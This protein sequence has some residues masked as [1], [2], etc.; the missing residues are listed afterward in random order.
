[1]GRAPID[2]VAFG[3]R[4]HSAGH[5][6]VT[7]IAP[8]T[9]GEEL[10]A[11]H[12]PTSSSPTLRRAVLGRPRVGWGQRLGLESLA[13]PRAA[14]RMLRW[15]GRS[16]GSTCNRPASPL[17]YGLLVLGHRRALLIATPSGD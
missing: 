6:A 7:G 10:F 15:S 13:A 11:L 5:P 4:P 8:T 17:L 14:S 9:G 2:G 16:Y 1:H 12:T 3:M